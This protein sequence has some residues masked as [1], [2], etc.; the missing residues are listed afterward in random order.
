MSGIKKFIQSSC[1]TLL[2]F[3]FSI[4]LHI[5]ALLDFQC[6]NHVFF[7]LIV[8]ISYQVIFPVEF[9]FCLDARI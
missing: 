5:Y 7:Y 6:K 2:A 9:S 4:R 1:E 8:R 3:T